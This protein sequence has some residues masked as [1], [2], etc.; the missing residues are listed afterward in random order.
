MPLLAALVVGACSDPGTH[1]PVPPRVLRADTAV[2]EGS[3]VSYPEGDPIAGMPVLV[4]DVRARY[5]YVYTDDDGSFRAEGLDAWFYRLKAWPLDDQDYIGAYYDDTYF[6]CTGTLVDLRNDDL[7]EGIDIRLPHGGAVEGTITDAATGDPIDGARVDLRGLDYYNTNIDPTYTTG[8]EG[9]YRF[10]GLDSAYDN[11]TDMNPVP[12]NYELKVTVAGRPVVYWP[13]VYS[14]ADIEYV[15]AL[16]GET[17][18]GFDLAIPLGATV[19]GTVLGPDGLPL[20]GGAVYLRHTTDTWI[21]ANVSIGTDG[22]FAAT[23]LAPGPYALQISASGYATTIPT[24]AVEVDED[25]TTDGMEFQLDLESVL[26]GMVLADGL[27]Q[28]G[29]TVR[30]SNPTTGLGESATTDSDGVFTVDGLA[31]GSFTVYV[32]AGDDLRA[33]GYLCDDGVCRDSTEATQIDLGNAERRDL[34]EIVLPPAGVIAGRVVERSTG[35]PLERI[36]VTALP[37]Y[38]SGS[39]HTDVTDAEG[40]FRFGGLLDAGYQLMAEPYRYCS[41]DPGWVTTYSGDARRIDDAVVLET[42]M[43][44]QVELELSLPRDH[45]GDGMADL[46]EHDHQLDMTRDDSLDDPDLDGVANVDEYLEATNPRDDR[47]GT[48]AGCQG[49]PGRGPVVAT[50]VVFVLLAIR[51]RVSGGPTRR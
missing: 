26:T 5:Q 12:G 9:T 11:A 44:Q 29:T 10:V 18:A 22:T 48:A 51:R 50:S 37:A 27:A 6:Y 24:D 36:Y 19:A 14:S 40:A 32:S 2:I 41:D 8:A 20:T 25:G 43:G 21:Q 49:A 34:G 30:A 4:V 46:W 31:A 23:G 35:V 1:D 3:V 38:G 33:S 15:E 17:S 47:G 7:I 42:L 45:D 13:G 28:A 39:T 16:R